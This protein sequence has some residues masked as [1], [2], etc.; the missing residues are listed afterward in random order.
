MDERKRLDNELD[1]G[2]QGAEATP[3]QPWH[4]PVI[5]VVPLRSAQAQAGAGADGGSTGGS[6]IC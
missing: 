3:R 6:T 1:S 5:D 4:P 2:L